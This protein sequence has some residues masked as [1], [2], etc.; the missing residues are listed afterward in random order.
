MIIDLD[1]GTVL[2]NKCVY[3]PDR[4]IDEETL[5]EMLDSDSL[6]IQIGEKF[7]KPLL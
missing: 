3:I 1:S 5:E 4:L 2:G 6:A 7:G